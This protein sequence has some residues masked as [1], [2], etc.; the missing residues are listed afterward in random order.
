VNQKQIQAQKAFRTEQLGMAIRL[1]SAGYTERARVILKELI[2]GQPE[3]VVAWLWLSET[4]P[5]DSSKRIKLLEMALETNRGNP[6]LL[7]AL[8][9]A[10]ISSESVD[11]PQFFIQNLEAESAVSATG[12]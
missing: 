4:F 1:L 9:K 10:Q 7:N 8:K 3:N 5:F 2:C 6:V 11:P 12:L